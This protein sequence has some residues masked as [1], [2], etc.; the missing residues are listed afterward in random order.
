MVSTAFTSPVLRQADF[1]LQPDIKFLPTH[2][3]HGVPVA[4]HRRRYRIALVN[5]T[6]PAD[7]ALQPLPSRHL[8]TGTD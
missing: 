2:Y 8:L 1:W 6:L 4:Q 7:D 3:G 5:H